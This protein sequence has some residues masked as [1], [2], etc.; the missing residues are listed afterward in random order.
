VRYFKEASSINFRR[1]SKYGIET[2][3]A[4]ALFW[5]NRLGI[6]R[7]KIFQRN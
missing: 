2:L 6:W 3:K 5:L 1:S 4:V 7:S